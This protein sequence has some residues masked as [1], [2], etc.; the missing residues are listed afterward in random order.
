MFRAEVILT[1]LYSVS[2]FIL[3]RLL[4]YM[5]KLKVGDEFRRVFFKAKRLRHILRQC[6]KITSIFQCGL[7]TISSSR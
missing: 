4:E 3:R 5:C 2:S 6:T 7:V 1:G